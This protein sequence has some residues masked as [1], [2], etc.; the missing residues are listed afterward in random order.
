[1]KVFISHSSV[2]KVF[3]TRL[4]TDLRTRAGIDA[5]LDRWE[6]MPGDRIPEKLEGG[7]SEAEALI[8]VLSPDSVKSQWVEYERQAWLMMQIEE[9]KRAKSE[10]RLPARRLLPVLYRD[11]QKPVFL[12]PFLHVPITD[13]GYQDGFEQLVRAI[14]RESTKP[15]LLGDN[16]AA[17]GS[18]VG[19]TAKATTVPEPG[20][21][22][23]VYA[24]TLLKSLVPAMFDE[25]V[26]L[27]NMPGA[28][29]PSGVPQVQKAIAL[30][31][32]A[33]QREGDTMTE[34]LNTITAVA[35]HLKDRG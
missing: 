11:C 13:E 12:Q 15:P 14:R 25:I 21:P 30:L 29:L 28:Y 34:L 7:L 20:V 22:H 33:Q 3:V 24:L 26:F 1:M 17:I 5:W 27:Y 6:I 10:S 16:G 18:L 32:Y 31:E 2:D 23:R 19:N 35:L 9:E 8:F 4:A